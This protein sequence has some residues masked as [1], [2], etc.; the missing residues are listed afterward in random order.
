M[1]LRLLEAI[2]SDCVDL[3]AAS[4]PLSFDEG[5]RRVGGRD[6]DVGLPNRRFRRP[7]R[8]NG[9]P[10]EGDHLL[11]EALATR[12]V[13]TVAAD[14]TNR[15]DRADGLQLA[16]RLP[17]RA[18][19]PDRRGIRS[20]EIFRR[21]TGCRPGP[22]LS[23]PIRLNHRDEFTG[24]DIEQVNPESD[25]RARRRVILEPGVSARRPRCEHD[26]D[27]GLPSSD[28]LPR[29]V[30]C[31]ASSQGPHSF[32]DGPQ[33][34][35]HSE[36]AL[37]VLLRQEQRGHRIAAYPDTAYFMALSKR[38]AI[39]ATAKAVLYRSNAQRFSPAACA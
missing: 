27:R 32:L 17:S 21:H 5:T 37:D 38:E 14:P 36:E 16:L 24:R 28:A 7:C 1:E 4:E 6:G 9:H 3:S 15:A 2:C 25:S 12:F 30:R 18:N 33:R 26:I 39:V 23:Q 31:L 8:V 29:A 22:L 35:R 11:R 19:D 10:E 13:P 34:V 20:R